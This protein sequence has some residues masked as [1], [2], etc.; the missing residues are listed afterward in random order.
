M[1]KSLL[2]HGTIV[3][4]IDNKLEV[5]EG[6]YIAVKDG[7]ITEISRTP[8]EGDFQLVET[9][10][11]QLIIPGLIDTHIHAPQY[12]F[13]GCGLDL[14]LLQ[15][16]EKYTF[17]A[18]TK[19]ASVEHAKKVY[20][21]VV[22][23]TLTHGTTTACY[24]ATI[25]TESSHLLS[26]ICREHGQRAFVGK[27]SMDRNSPPTYCEETKKAID[28]A[29]EFVN[30]YPVDDDLVQPII[31]PRF[32]PTCTPELM[33]ALSEIQTHRPS[34]LIQS[35]VSENLGEIAWVQSLHPECENYCDVYR[36]YGLLGPKTI[37]AHGVHLTDD[38]LKMLNATGG[39]I[40]HCPSSN[41]QLFS[42]ACDIRRLQ[43]AGVKVGLGTD[44]AGGPS[45]SMIDAMRNALICSRSNLF[46]KRE[47][48]EDYVPLTV[49]E[50]LALATEGG[51]K[52]L[53]IDDKVGNFV[54]GKQF[55]A[56]IV[57]L[58]KGVCDCF[59]EE[60][61]GDLLDKFVHRGDDRNVVTV[62]VKGKQVK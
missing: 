28:S 30:Q 46:L 15:W 11:T 25:W 48:G 52:A 38:E 29:K 36:K 3:H 42:G 16:L 5:I 34:T 6:G 14:P 55:D 54:V 26:K 2:I 4:T 22:S 51:A 13:A 31:T 39:A 37:L 47:K 60:S 9:T 44:V 43:K 45:P 62:Y 32:V 24:F 20:E 58:T 7:M 17:P 1:T 35:H 10:K 8:I 40:A 27:V 41:F 61:I 12:V 23:R 33:L 19:F 18:E 59:G 49:P 56:L 21:A 50:V 57:D 53:G